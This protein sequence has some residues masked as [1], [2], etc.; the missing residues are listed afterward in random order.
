[1]RIDVEGQGHD[2]FATVAND[3]WFMTNLIEQL[4]VPA[5]ETSQIIQ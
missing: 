1:V 4:Q 2:Y 3:D 5:E